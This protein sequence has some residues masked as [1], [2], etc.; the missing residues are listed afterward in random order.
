MKLIP[1]DKDNRNAY[2]KFE[3]AE[4]CRVICPEYIRT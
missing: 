1:V 2:R 4:I 3:N